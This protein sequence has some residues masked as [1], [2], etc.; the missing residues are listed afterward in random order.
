[1]YTT[2]IE[3]AIRRAALLRPGD[4]VLCA[5]S[6]GADSVCLT[7]A[8]ARMREELRIE[9]R[10]AHFS[11]GIRLD[12]A[13][14]ERRLCQSLCDS[15][16]IRLYTGAGDTP[17]EAAQYKLSLEEAA[18]DLRMSFL[19]D[20]AQAWG[21]EAGLDFMEII[22]G[23]ILIA[24]GHNMEDQAETVLMNLIRGTGLAGLRGMEPRRRRFVRPL[25]EVPRA[26]IEGYVQA[27]GLDFATDES[28]LGS[29]YT[30]NKIRNR[31]MPLI[32][33]INPKAS[34]TLAR[35]AALAAQD[36]DY[37]T[38]QARQLM[39]ELP[40]PHDLTTVFSARELASAHPAVAG[41][42][43]LMACEKHMY[44][45]GRRHVE[46]VLALARSD[47]P[48]GR[49]DLPHLGVARREYDR[50]F[51]EP[52]ERVQ[53][54]LAADFGA[55][56]VELHLGQTVRWAGWE[57]T[58]SAQP[59][60]GAWCFRRE[61]VDFPLTVRQRQEGDRICLGNHHKTLKKWMIERKIP[62]N[63]RDIVPVLWDNKGVLCVGTL[64]ADQ[65]RVAVQ[66]EAGETV[67]IRICPTQET[68][69]LEGAEI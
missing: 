38:A 36:F 61:A 26:A 54:W 50:L 2:P 21:R 10:A 18:R 40:P 29:D 27:H 13:E 59:L 16:G 51:I 65:S 62:K 63:I 47:D 32:R 22:R 48:S 23:G 68:D 52:V 64:G 67:S 56:A 1:M 42:A 49:I 4:R 31:I 24:T 14:G 5:L 17:A 41:R 46:A 34:R 28:N 37:I 60:D 55:K 12:A 3:A 57:I 15:L 69:Y 43:V 35:G 8:L 20:T 25:L 44:R 11:H 33:E 39:T 7:H 9:V 45:V 30:R 19:R 53:G 6:G 58:A 66:F